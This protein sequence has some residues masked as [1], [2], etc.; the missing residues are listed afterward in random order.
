M[1]TTHLN[2]PEIAENQDQK[3]VTHNEAL[4]HLDAIVQLSVLDKDLSLPPSSP[5]EGDRYIVG[6]APTGAWAIHR[7]EIAVWD[8]SGWIFLTPRNGWVCYIADENSTYQFYNSTWNT[9]A[10][11][12]MQNSFE[13]NI[14]SVSKTS[15][16][17]IRAVWSTISNFDTN[18][19]TISGDIN[20]DSAAGTV[21]L[22]SIGRFLV[23]FSM[24]FSL[25]R[26]GSSSTAGVVEAELRR[27][28][29]ATYTFIPGTS[30][31]DSEAGLFSWTGILLNSNINTG[32]RL[33]VRKT[34]RE[35]M[36]RV[37][38]CTLTIVKLT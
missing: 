33:A 6:P 26:P 17:D 14:L 35:I 22:G 32:Y 23:S 24:E 13:D 21:I 10:S 36:S 9:F 19:I 28:S 7:N 25:T 18:H 20:W 2:L 30:Y 8:N 15:L 4:F 1:T 38:N 29:G 5:S 34:S 37:S 27:G 3:H 12:I 16:Q 11:A 31:D